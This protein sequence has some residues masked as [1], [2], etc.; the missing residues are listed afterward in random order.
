MRG[1]VSE[2]LKPFLEQV[3]QQIA[4]AQLEQV[5][6]TPELVRGNLNKLA[7]L[8]SIS[9][10]LAYVKQA[11]IIAQND[12]VP[13]RVYSPAPNEALPVL[14]YFH[15]GGHMCGSVELYDPMCRKIAIAGHCIVISVEYRLAP[16]HPYPA[17]IDD[18][19]IALINYQQVLTELAFN[20]QIYIGGDSAGG[21]ICTTLSM[22]SLEDPQLH[23]DKQILIYPSVD[24]TMSSQSFEENG[25]GFLLE[26]GKVK[27]YFEQY[28][29]HNENAKRASPLEGPITNALPTSFIITAGCDPL[30]DEG[31]AYAGALTAAGVCVKHIQFD[32]MIHAFMNIEDLVPEECQRLYQ[33]IGNFINNIA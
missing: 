30:R 24:Y 16:E 15:G 11:E 26:Q 12:K 5:Q 1:K 31:I 23:I 14:L 28:F 9:P 33:A 21:A 25:T 13:V 4:Q 27:W 17:G 29:Q 3:N 18:G 32:D 20:E 10:E 19:Q 2:K 8:T 7:A 6:I 22:L